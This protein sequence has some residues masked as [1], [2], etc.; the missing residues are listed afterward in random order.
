MWLLRLGCLPVAHV[1][2]QNDM[3]PEHKLAKAAN[4][5]EPLPL[6]RQPNGRCSWQHLQNSCSSNSS[7]WR[8]LLPLNMC[9][10]LTG[11][12]ASEPM[13]DLQ[14]T[15]SPSF[16]LFPLCSFLLLLFSCSICCSACVYCMSRR[17]KLPST[18]PDTELLASMASNHTVKLHIA[19]GQWGEKSSSP[20]SLFYSFSIVSFLSFSLATAWAPR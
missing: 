5:G 12:R 6:L 7:N 10:Y 15:W 3:K 14:T 9:G 18:L 2:T 17:F 1:K 4:W 11:S 19:M 8:R 16:L 20:Q 13:I